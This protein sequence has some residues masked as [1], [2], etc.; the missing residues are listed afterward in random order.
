MVDHSRARRALLARDTLA[1]RNPAW[2]TM[3]QVEQLLAGAAASAD[4]DGLG[5]TEFLPGDAA[6][7]RDMPRRP[8]LPGG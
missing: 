8:P 5:L 3:T 1:W 2:A 7:L 6:A 4:L